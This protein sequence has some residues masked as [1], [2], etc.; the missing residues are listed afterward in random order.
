MPGLAFHHQR[1]LLLPRLRKHCGWQV[2]QVVLVLVS[3]PLTMT[4]GAAAQQ[5]RSRAF[6]AA[7]SPAQNARPAL[8]LQRARAE[9]AAMQAQPRSANLT[10]AWQALGP[11]GLS[12]ATFGTLTGRVSALAADPNDASGNT[13]YAGTTGGGVWKS[14]NAAGALSAASFTP[15]TDT[16]A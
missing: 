5:V 15:L 7:R 9:H 3:V 12:S 2:W 10:A 1:Q 11:V 16:K 13:P 8:G 14:T 4:G 6:V